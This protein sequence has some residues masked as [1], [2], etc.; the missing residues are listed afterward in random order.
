MLQPVICKLKPK[1]SQWQRFG[2]SPRPETRKADNGL[3]S[4]LSAGFPGV[5]DGKE[6]DC[7]YRRQKGCRFNPW[8]RRISW[9]RKGQP[10]PAFLPE[11]S[12]EQKG[13][14]GC[15]GQTRGSQVR[16][17]WATEQHI[18]AECRRKPMSQL[19]N[20]QRG[21]ILSSSIFQSFWNSQWV[22]WGP[23][24]LRRACESACWIKC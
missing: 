12:H 21:Q 10:T 9:R 6:S 17:D 22:W 7:Q 11:K 1:G 19:E 8:V 14:A 20:R 5:A 13:L 3:S 4:E 24:T 16:H 18:Q 23:P 15:K 2:P